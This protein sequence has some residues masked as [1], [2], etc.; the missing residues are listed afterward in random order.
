MLSVLPHASWNQAVDYIGPRLE[1]WIA[2]W[3]RE[4]GNERPVPSYIPSTPLVAAAQI[5]IDD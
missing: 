2:A 4:R 1:R 3:P 5:T